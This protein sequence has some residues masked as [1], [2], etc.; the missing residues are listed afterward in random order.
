MGIAQQEADQLYPDEILSTSCMIVDDK[1]GDR[2]IYI[3]GRTAEPCK[4][5]LEAVVQELGV[6]LGKLDLWDNFLGVCYD[7][8]GNIHC[9][10][11][12]VFAPEPEEVLRHLA[13]ACLTAARKAVM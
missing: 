10:C 9:G 5:Q 3:A 13:E 4:E 8:R 12:S 11:G 1:S 6:H 7:D 2:N